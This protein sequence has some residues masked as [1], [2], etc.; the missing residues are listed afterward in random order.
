MAQKG[1]DT[2]DMNTHQPISIEFPV[3]WGELDALGHVN[4]TRFLVWMESARMAFFEEIGLD[5]EN[6]PKRGPI[7]ANVEVSYRMPVHYPA[8][9]SCQVLV[10]RIGNS[11]FVLEYVLTLVS[12]PEN[13]VADGRTVIVLYNYEES[14]KAV[15]PD[16]IRAMLRR[17]S[18]G[19]DV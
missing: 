16:E 18:R 7:L 2:R 10:G 6:A 4:H 14:T 9:V 12:D 1:E 19:G 13:V 5:W 8:R 17:F 11:S 15:I 3:H